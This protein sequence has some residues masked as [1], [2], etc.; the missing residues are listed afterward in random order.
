MTEE[1][2]ELGDPNYQPKTNYQKPESNEPE[3]LSK[4]QMNVT[5]PVAGLI[6]PLRLAPLT[7]TLIHISLSAL[8]ARALAFTM[9]VLWLDIGR[10]LQDRRNRPHAV[11]AEVTVA[12]VG[13]QDFIM[14]CSPCLFIVFSLL[15]QTR[16]CRGATLCDCQLRDFD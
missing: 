4:D 1:S 13:D 6:V 14:S 2:W 11:G 9:N 15:L 8:F 5:S 12:G 10:L 3:E 7:L 16:P